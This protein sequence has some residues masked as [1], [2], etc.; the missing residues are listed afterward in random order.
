L[1]SSFNHTI[2]VK[3]P[4]SGFVLNR[5]SS[6]V[7]PTPTYIENVPTA[8]PDA[9]G[10]WYYDRSA[11]YI[12]FNPAANQVPFLK[13]GEVWVAAQTTLL[14]GI[15]VVGHTW[16][17]VTFQYG[18][19][20]GPS[21]N[22][23]YVDVQTAVHSC[24]PKNCESHPVVPAFRR[25]HAAFASAFSALPSKVVGR[26]RPQGTPEGTA[27][28]WG[29]VW[30]SH[31]RNISFERCTFQAMGGAY[32]L[33][34]GDASQNIVVDSFSFNDLSGGFLKLGN[35]NNTRAVTNDTSQ[36]DSYLAV[37]NNIVVDVALEYTG[38]AALFA[39]YVAYSKI[40]HNTIHSTGYTGISLG[41][42]W[43]SVVSFARH[44]SITNNL[45]YD[46]MRALVDGGCIYTLGPQPHSIVQGNYVHHDH[47]EYGVLYHDNGSRY[48]NTSHN[49]VANSSAPAVFLQGCCGS[50]AWNLTVS[51]IYYRFVDGVR[52]DCAP[53][54][55]TVDNSTV[56]DVG[57]HAWPPAAES[58]I[59]NAGVPR[60]AVERRS[61]NPYLEK[62]QRAVN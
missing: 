17:G 53:Q 57:S 12:F 6:D 54:G 13:Q 25:S 3:Y 33:A 35:V 14:S 60:S 38:A 37:T 36:W 51:Y 28:P 52:N 49:V 20:F 61:L 9:E 34:F 48:F 1:A 10:Q 22:D 50:P 43:G 7:L 4:C 16:Q 42:G 31:C 56:F 47:A 19:W 24:S 23:G 39:G 18:T 29:N 55:C 8:A 44:N 59:Q 46:V 21:S 11:G 41:W 62:M 5:A 32:A 2:T 15:D 40:D 26:S 45:V 58:I 27:E 30:F